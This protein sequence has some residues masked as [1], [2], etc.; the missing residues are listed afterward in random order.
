[1]TAVNTARSLA[2][3]S[4]VSMSWGAAETGSS[5]LGNMIDYDSYFT[6]PA[7]H[8]GVTFLASTGDN[9][10]SGEWPSLSSNV[11]AVG[12]TSLTIN[13]STFA[14]V[15]ET[16]WSTARQQRRPKRLRD[17]TFLPER[18]AVVRLSSDP[19]RIVRRRPRH[20]RGRLRFVRLQRGPAE[21]V[22][23]VGSGR[24]HQPRGAVLG[25]PGRHRRPTPRRPRPG[26]AERPRS[27]P[28]RP[29]TPCP[30]PTSTTSPAAATTASRP[31]RATMKSPASALPW[32]TC[33]CRPWQP[34]PLP[35]PRPTRPT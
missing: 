11:V 1:M 13:G 18:R 29:S 21:H 6:T 20:G 8:T 3:V 32:P 23:P 14:Y 12:G 26:N 5:G 24:R 17:R 27:R 2:G 10:S 33:S 16:A 22:Q 30:P 4:V 7:G 31:G 25:G 9:G 28:C 35:F 19:G 15:S 34:L